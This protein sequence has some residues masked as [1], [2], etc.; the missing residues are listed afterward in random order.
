MEKSIE[1]VLDREMQCSNCQQNF[2]LTDGFTYKISEESSNSDLV[3]GELIQHGTFYDDLYIC[4]KCTDPIYN[5]G[6]KFK[7]SC[8]AKT[9]VMNNNNEDLFLAG[10]TDDELNIERIISPSLH[11][12]ATRHSNLVDEVKRIILKKGRKEFVNEFCDI[13]EMKIQLPNPQE[14][15]HHGSSKEKKVWT[16]WLEEKQKSLFLDFYRK[17]MD[18]MNIETIAKTIGPLLEYGDID[19]DIIEKLDNN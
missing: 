2:F 15:I 12:F 19:K 9:F 1:G 10:F 5:D 18:T 3:K 6:A 4:H 16:Q 7:D 14:F 11:D 17:F 13:M 8:P